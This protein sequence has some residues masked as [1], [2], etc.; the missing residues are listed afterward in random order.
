M[1]TKN[2][3]K[4]KPQIDWSKQSSCV[5][6]YAV[7]EDGSHLAIMRPEVG[8]YGA[9]MWNNT[10]GWVCESKYGICLT[11][12]ASDSPL[13]GYTGKPEDSL[14]MRPRE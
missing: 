11:I 4:K 9:P 5:V 12:R 3:I 7:D 1:P 13:N 8:E 10:I 6:G 14:H 2:T